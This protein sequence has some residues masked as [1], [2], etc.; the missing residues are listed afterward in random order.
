MEPARRG[1][2]RNGEGCEAERIEGREVAM[3]ERLGAGDMGR[4]VG[5]G[6]RASAISAPIRSP[7]R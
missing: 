7:D 2:R 6:R 1:A 5:E 4:S 3:H